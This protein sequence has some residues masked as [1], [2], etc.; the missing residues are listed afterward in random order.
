M[1]GRTPVAVRPGGRAVRRLRGRLERQPGDQ[2]LVGRLGAAP[3]IDRALHGRRVATRDRRGERPPLG[4]VDRA[5]TA[6]S[7]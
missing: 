4:R 2:P 7:T 5:A 1:A 6:A 3:V